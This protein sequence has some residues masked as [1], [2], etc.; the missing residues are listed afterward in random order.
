MYH[1]V[2]SYDTSDILLCIAGGKSACID[3]SRTFS[4]EFDDAN[5][6]HSH[7]SIAVTN[8]YDLQWYVKY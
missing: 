5:A 6:T 2:F 7:S 3:V 8:R 4:V 1:L